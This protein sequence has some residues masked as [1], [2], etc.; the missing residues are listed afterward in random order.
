[1]EPYLITPESLAVLGALI[2]G[3][4]QE[5]IVTGDLIGM[6]MEDPGHDHEI[7]AVVLLRERNGWMEIVWICLRDAYRGMHFCFL[8]GSKIT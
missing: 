6:V 2:P 7:A 4:Y 8:H 1:M 3:E 5:E